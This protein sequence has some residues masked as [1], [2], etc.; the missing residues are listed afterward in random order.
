MGEIAALG[1]AV[2]WM[3]SA[4]SFETAGK[5]IGSLSLNMIRLVMAF[6]LLGLYALVVRG[7]FFP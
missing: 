5:R 3:V 6:G 4:L 2:C 7:E 1:T